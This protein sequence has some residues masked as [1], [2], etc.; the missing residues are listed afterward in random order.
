MVRVLKLKTMSINLKTVYCT[1]PWY[2]YLSK[3]TR[4][5]DTVDLN[6]RCDVAGLLGAEWTGLHSLH[7]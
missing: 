5:T 2:T 7:D 1:V 6:L 4:R 3:G